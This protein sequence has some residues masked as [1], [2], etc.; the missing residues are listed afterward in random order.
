MAPRIFTLLRS[1][2]T[3]I[4]GGHPTRLQVAWSVESCRKLASSVKMSAPRRA[5]AFFLGRD[6]CCGAIG[7]ALQRRRAPVR[8]EA[9]A[10]K[11]PSREVIC[12]HGQDDTECRTPSRSPR[13]SWAR[14]RCRY[15]DRKLPGRCREYPPTVS[16]V[17]LT[18]PMDARP[19]PFQ[20]T[21][22]AVGLISL[23]PLR[24]FGSGGLQDLRQFAARM[25]FGIQRHGAQSFRHT[26]GPFS[27]RF[28]AQTNQP[29]IC[30][31]MQLQQAWHHKASAAQ[32]VTCPFS[33]ARKYR[34]PRIST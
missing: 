13:Q 2:V 23:E 5:G 29:L 34:M 30:A 10:L 1:P 21:I 4:S 22:D 9:V 20:Q 12:A 26:V 27:F 15:P 17:S 11:I 8:G 19:V 3:G 7:P 25:S 14:S 6:R 31:G 28:F 18:S 16:V 32:Y 33:Y 24:Y